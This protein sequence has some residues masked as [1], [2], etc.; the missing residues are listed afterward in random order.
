MQAVQ[1]Y[2]KCQSSPTPT[3]NSPSGDVVLITKADLDGYH[4]S[5]DAGREMAI[6]AKAPKANNMAMV[7]RLS[8]LFASLKVSGS[9][10]SVRIIRRLPVSEAQAC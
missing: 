10:T 9:G 4:N 8:C 2:S 1:N 7:S 6:V 3:P 5:C